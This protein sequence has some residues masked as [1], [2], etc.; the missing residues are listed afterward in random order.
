[1]INFKGYKGTLYRRL[2]RYF[3]IKNSNGNF[4]SKGSSIH[5]K[6]IIG[7]GSRINGPITIKGAGE[8]EIGNYGAIGSDVKIITSNHKTDVINLQYAL[9]KRIGL[10]LEVDKK[11]GV[12]IGH[13][14]WI[15]DNSLILPNVTVGNGAVIAAG[16][17]ITKDVDPYSIVA[18][19]PASHK[20]F[21]FSK[22]KISEIESTKWWYWDIEKMKENKHFFEKR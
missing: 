6:T 1:M 21:R 9:S 22:E 19:V 2:L 17:I 15:G 5:G 7:I 12:T 14:V 3:N 20:R 4:I 16:S 8:C 18:G 11:T 13:N 10:D